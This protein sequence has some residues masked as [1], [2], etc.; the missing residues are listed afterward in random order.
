[1]H[2]SLIYMYCMFFSI[3][4]LAQGPVLQVKSFTDIMN[5]KWKTLSFVVP[6][7]RST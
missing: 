5:A 3:R 2:I 4:Q 7:K 1:M 6:V